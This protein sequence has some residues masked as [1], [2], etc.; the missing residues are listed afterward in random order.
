MPKVPKITC[1]SLHISRKAWGDKVDFLPADKHK[2]FLQ[3]DGITS[4]VHSQACPESQNN[5]F[6]DVFVIFKGKHEG[7]SWSFAY[8]WTSKVS[9]CCYYHF[10][11]VWSGMP[12]LP[13]I[14]SL[15]FLR[16]ILR[17]K[18]VMKLIFCMQISI[19]ACYK[20]LLW[21]WWGWSS[22]A[23]VPN[24]ASLQCLYNISKNNLKVKLI[25]CT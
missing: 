11:C 9:S 5:K 6:T 14:T 1:I 3:V 15:L 10:R 18:W 25:F 16:N 7:W 13:K 24:I 12:K 8:K 19:K 21:F 22:I 4:G 20:L 2:S 17:K 23:K